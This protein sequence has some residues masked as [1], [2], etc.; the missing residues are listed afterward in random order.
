MPPLKLPPSKGIH[1]SGPETALKPSVPACWISRQWR[2]FFPE[3]CWYTSPLSRAP[4]LGQSPPPPPALVK[5]LGRQLTP[6]HEPVET[7]QS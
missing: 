6:V 2:N 7:W 5:G 3:E 4:F 1:L